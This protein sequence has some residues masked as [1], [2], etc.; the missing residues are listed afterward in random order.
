MGLH[1]DLPSSP[2]NP[3]SSLSLVARPNL[4]GADGEAV[5]AAGG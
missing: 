2:L 1:G 5:G 4:V 3:S